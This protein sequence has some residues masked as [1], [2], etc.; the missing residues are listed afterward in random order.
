MSTTAFLSMWFSNTASTAVMLPIANAVMQQ[1]SDTKAN[2][3][4]VFDP[5][6][7]R[8]GQDNQAYEMDDTNEGSGLRWYV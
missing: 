1:L 8:D 7:A 2:A 5:C 6:S 4:R 3:E